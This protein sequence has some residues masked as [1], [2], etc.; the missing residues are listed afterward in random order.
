VTVLETSRLRLVPC[1]VELAIAFVADARSLAAGLLAAELPDGWPDGELAG[2]LPGYA[3]A[4][5]AEPELLGWGPWI[6]VEGERVAGS[7]GFLGQPVGGTVELG[8]GIAPEARGRG[9][10]TEAAQALVAWALADP[11]VRD[12]VAEVEP[13]NQ[14]SYRVLEKIG[15][16]RAGTVNG[17]ERWALTLPKRGLT[18]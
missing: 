9:V 3:Q 6:V 16:R 8:Y 12:V 10:A 2:L 17:H 13:G 14:A 4:I 7:A 1:S 15:M 11:R 18:P 5:A